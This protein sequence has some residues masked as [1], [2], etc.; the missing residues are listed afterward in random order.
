[1]SGISL[2][3]KAKSKSKKKSTV[4]KRGNAFTDDK[5]ADR[6]SK[7]VKIKITEVEAYKEPQE[8]AL[9][10]PLAVPS[11]AS[12]ELT[13]T[14]SD[15]KSEINY[16]LN[17]QQDH[18]VT[19]SNARVVNSTGMSDILDITKLPE[20]TA[21]DEYD[22]VPVNMF[23]AALLRGM[24]WTG[25]NYDDE[26]NDQDRE[27]SN[28]KTA[29][30]PHHGVARPEFVG[31]GAKVQQSNTEETRR[32]SGLDKFMPIVRV[33]HPFTNEKSK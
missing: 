10:I 28:N 15:E 7:R 3:L 13:L 29:V 17:V 22:E 21:Q 20:A 11:G 26:D 12:R 14:T 31:I 27:K 5:E 4:R 1:M 33:E 25:T 8:E 23:G 32:G 30:R 6:N 18:K 9:V 16:G 19:S 24:G 2:S